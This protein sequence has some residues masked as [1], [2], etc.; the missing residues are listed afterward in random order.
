MKEKFTSFYFDVAK[1]VAELSHA[2]RLKVG[3]VIVKDHRI[4]SYGYNGM[5]AGFDNV[6]EN[7]ERTFDERDTY[8]ERDE[9]TYDKKR[10]H[11]TRLRTKPEVIHAEMNAIA[12]VAFH[13]DSCKNATMF[14]TH[15]PCVECAKMIL[16]SGIND[17]WYIQ[18]YRSKDGINL[19]KAGKVIVI[20]ER[21]KTDE[22]EDPVL[23]ASTKLSRNY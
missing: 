19:L 23:Y 22:Q 3:A 1:R 14:L 20:K 16:Q 18:D 11:Y 6:C 12:K 9:W 2:E 13:G 17:V 10:K 4:L 15:S 21:E 7:V 8:F 5:P